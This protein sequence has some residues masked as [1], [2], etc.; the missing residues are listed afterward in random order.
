[1]KKSTVVFCIILFLSLFLISCAPN[2]NAESDSLSFV[3]TEGKD[4]IDLNGEKLTIKGVNIGNWLVPEGWMGVIDIDGQNDEIDGEKLT[5]KKMISAL[6]NNP[7]NFNQ[8]DILKILDAYYENWFNEYD[9]KFI[10]DAGFNC[11]RL[12]FGY[13]NLADDDGNIFDDGF[14]WIDKCLEW[15]QKYSIYC[16][17][18]MHGAFGSQNKEHHSGD[19]TQCVLFDDSESQMKTADL[20]RAIAFRYKNNRYVLGY[21][22]L[23]E[24]KGNSNQTLDVQHEVHKM[25]YDAIREVDKNHIVILESCWQFS[26]FPNIAKY[27]FENT[28]YEMHLY[29]FNKNTSVF[30][31]GHLFMYSICQ[32]LHDK[33]VYIGEFCLGDGDLEYTINVFEEYDFHWTSW[34]YKTNNCG[35]WGLNNINVPRVNVS[36]ATLEQII[37][38][39]ESCNSK[40]AS[41]S[42]EFERLLSI[43]K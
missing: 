33:P 40:N 24:P 23:N 28:V 5:Y 7:N 10:K 4:I 6:L 12:P 25:L 14:K 22:L 19:D 21:D 15:C 26:D 32:Q 17:L 3:H 1:M 9:V 36:S 42:A 37:A 20:W 31:A 13:F 30:L 27:K 2:N 39:F 43:I 18:D 8:A 38:C 41:A 34:S 16:I 11:I 35:G 29:N